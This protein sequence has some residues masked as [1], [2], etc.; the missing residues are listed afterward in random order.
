MI[1]LAKYEYSRQAVDMLDEDYPAKLKDYPA[2]LNKIPS[3][4]PSLPK[5]TTSKELMK[6]ARELEKQEKR[7]KK[8][9][10]ETKRL[11]RRNVKD[12][13]TIRNTLLSV[14]EG[15]DQKARVLAAEKLHTF[16]YSHGYTEYE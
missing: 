5:P 12:R 16:S 4:M 3:M 9:K 10:R 7:A 13:E 1:E 6:R 11:T 15:K 8:A 2:K 14:M